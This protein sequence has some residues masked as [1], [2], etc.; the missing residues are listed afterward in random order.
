MSLPDFSIKRPITV[1]CIFILSLIMGVI[2]LNRIGVDLYPDVSFPIVSISTVYNG[3]SPEEIE[4]L[5][6]KPIED[7]LSTIS[8][9]KS[10]KSTNKEGLEFQFG[11]MS[12]HAGKFIFNA[13]PDQKLKKSWA[14][15]IKQLQE[16]LSLDG[17]ISMYI[18][19][20]GAMKITVDSGLITYDYILPAQ[21]K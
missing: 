6:T 5:V 16:I 10:V 1:T 21:A 15:P 11:D 3:A 12:S 20:D 14:Y 4:F 19:D 7:D 13:D 9:I 17:E 2:S 8:G 18:S